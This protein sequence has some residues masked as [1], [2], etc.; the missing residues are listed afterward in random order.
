MSGKGSKQRPRFVDEGTFDSNWD[1]IFSKKEETVQ[2][3][4]PRKFRCIQCGEV[5]FSRYSGEFVSC[6]CGNYVDQTMHYIRIGGK[7]S[8]E[9]INENV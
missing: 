9:D 6:S 5:I 3:F 4:K 7:G 1:K 2:E 8:L